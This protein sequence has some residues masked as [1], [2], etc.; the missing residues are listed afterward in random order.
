MYI[1]SRTAVQDY[2]EN[3]EKFI[4]DVLAVIIKITLSFFF[5]Y[6]VSLVLNKDIFQM[7]I[8]FLAIIELSG[9]KIWA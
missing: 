3:P 7:W 2:Y 4:V 1:F 9:V 8:I 6:L 5:I